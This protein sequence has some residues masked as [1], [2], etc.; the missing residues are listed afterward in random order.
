MRLR[1]RALRCGLRRGPALSWGGHGPAVGAG[2]GLCRGNRSPW[3]CRALSPPPCPGPVWGPDLALEGLCPT[4]EGCRK[5]PA[6][7]AGGGGSAGWAGSG[8]P[9]R[10]RRRVQGPALRPQARPAL[11]W[12]RSRV[13][14]GAGK[15]RVRVYCGGRRALSEPSAAPLPRR[16]RCGERRAAPHR[17]QGSAGVPRDCGG[18]GSGAGGYTQTAFCVFPLGF[19]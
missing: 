16:Q 4:L 15:P 6:G 8:A 14:G 10:H 9:R 1:G 17:A 11:T 2:M 12:K 19:A 18:R 5:L 13:P 3:L 7:P